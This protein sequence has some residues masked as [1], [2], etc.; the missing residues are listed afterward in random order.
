M[1]W[2]EEGGVLCAGVKREGVVCW[3][4]MERCDGAGVKREE[5]DVLG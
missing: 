3:V 2:G 4:K 5:C 1:C